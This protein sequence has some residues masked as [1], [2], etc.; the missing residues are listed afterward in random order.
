MAHLQRARESDTESLR[1]LECERAT[2]K[3]ECE[4]LRHTHETLGRYRPGRTSDVHALLDRM[5]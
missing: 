5:G 1:A 2:L 3:A 4:Q